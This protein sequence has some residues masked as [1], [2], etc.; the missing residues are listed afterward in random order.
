M[1][2]DMENWRAIFMFCTS[3]LIVLLYGY[4]FFARIF[5]AT[6]T[7]LWTTDAVQVI[8]YFA[9]GVVGYYSPKRGDTQALAVRGLLLIVCIVGGIYLLRE[10]FFGGMSTPLILSPL[11]L[12][13]SLFSIVRQGRMR[14]RSKRNEE[15]T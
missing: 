6:T 5:G 7:P 9:F 11:Y 15:A 13:L 1:R 2:G 12:A 4:Y 10:I 3:L 14:P 8:V